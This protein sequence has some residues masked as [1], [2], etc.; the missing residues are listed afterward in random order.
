VNLELNHL[1]SHSLSLLSDMTAYIRP[2]QVIQ[3]RKPLDT[4]NELRFGCE[5]VLLC[6]AAQRHQL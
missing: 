5:K 4:V 1:I 2:E 6:S 3:E